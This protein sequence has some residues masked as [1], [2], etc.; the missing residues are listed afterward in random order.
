MP[1]DS[2]ILS[3]PYIMPAQAQKH[4]THNEALRVLDV[5]VQLV[6]QD[7][8]RTQPPTSSQEG[9]RHIVAPSATGEWS[10]QVG[11]IALR[12]HGQ[13]SFLVPRAGW[14]AHVLAEA[15][16]ATF[17]GQDWRSIAQ[18]PLEVQQ[19]GVSATPDAVN[20]LSVNASATLLNHAGGGHQLKIN[21]FA[22]IDT[23]SLLF[24]N[25]FSGRAEMGLS[26]TDHFA[27]KVSAD[28][29]NWA[30]ALRA[31][32]DSGRIVLPAGALT[33]DG[34]A[35]EPAMSF[36]GDPD[37]G[38]F[39]PAA[40]QIGLSAGGVT[41]A[42]ITGTGMTLTGLLSGTAVTQS[43][44]DATAGR[45]L[46]AGDGG[47]LGQ[48]IAPSSAI[49]IN[50]NTL[51]NGFYRFGAGVSGG[52]APAG[53]D[54]IWLHIARENGVR[55]HQVWF[56]Q[57]SVL[58]LVRSWG[59]SSWTGWSRI[60]NQGTVLGTVS[61]TAGV[62]TGAL[63]ER[64]ANANG[65]FARFAD[66]TQICTGVLPTLTSTSADSVVTF[67]AV[68]A[69]MPLASVIAQSGSVRVPVLAASPSTTSFSFNLFDASGGRQASTARWTALGRWF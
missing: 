31:K 6:V 64:G 25:G 5:I 62:P 38:M 7:R 39:R 68:F 29:S 30:E 67:P 69:V 9:D 43:P 8:T 55:A 60:Y 44:T 36:D 27:L 41:R 35:A 2:P 11:K 48:A 1:D 12:E 57:A 20:R 58:C 24:Q 46:K 63:I 47:I 21:K 34:T 66:G 19:L 56:S 37:T 15:S 51:P 16:L 32:G 45:L 52:T 4:I 59:G 53:S 50:D 28:G 33:G 14:R 54:G 26:G 13:W 18:M 3:L 61:Q 42:L 10:G 17:D 22:T 65:E 40:N 49:S 23:A